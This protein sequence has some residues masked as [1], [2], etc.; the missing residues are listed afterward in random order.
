MVS[1]RNVSQS[2]TYAL[3]CRSIQQVLDCFVGY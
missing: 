1:I 2:W 3:I